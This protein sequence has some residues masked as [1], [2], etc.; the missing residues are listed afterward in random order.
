M[1]IV[2]LTILKRAGA[3]DD[4][5]HT[6]NQRSEIFRL[7]QPCEIGGDPAGAGKAL[8]GLCGVA[9]EPGHRMTF[10]QKAGENGRADKAC[11][12]ENQDFHDFETRQ[13]SRG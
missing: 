9:A 10:R 4:G 7:G 1:E 11:G 12:A 5:I 2:G 13:Q 6:F 8:S 3:I